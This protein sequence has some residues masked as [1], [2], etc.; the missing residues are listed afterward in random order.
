MATLA[1]IRTRVRRRTDNEHTGDFVTNTE[2]N[3]L[4]NVKAMELYELLVIHGLHRAES[5]QT[6]SPTSA[7]LSYSLNADVFAILG[8]WGQSSS[9][10]IRR[11]LTRHDHRIYP[12]INTPADAET[13]RVAGSKIEFNPVPNKG[14]YTIRYVPIPTAMV[15]DT[16]TFDGMLGW[17]EWVVIAASLDV[18]TKEDGDPNTISRLERELYRQHDRIKMAAQNV[19]ISEYPSIA[20]VRD[21]AFDGLRLEGDFTSKG[22]RGLPW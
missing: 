13:Y 16:D 14:T 4:I 19:E 6:I 3:D 21:S 7:V 15:V 9:T 12:D 17:E 1:E 8:V 20:K 5:T 22:L 11:W 18:L 10:D 2:L